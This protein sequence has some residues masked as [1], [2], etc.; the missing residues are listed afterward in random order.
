MEKIIVLTEKA[1]TMLKP[2][3][4]KVEE[5]GVGYQHACYML[6]KSNERLWDCIREINPEITRAVKYPTFDHPDDGAGD[7]TITYLDE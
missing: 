1:K 7:W 5:A 3:I 2:L 6:K 4:N